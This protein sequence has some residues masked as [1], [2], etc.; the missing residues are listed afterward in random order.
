MSSFDYI[1]GYYGL[2]A[3]EGDRVVYSGSYVPV[4]GTIVGA[5]GAKLLIRLDGDAHPKPFHPEWKLEIVSA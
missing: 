2:S 5:Q 1:N 4:G 3:K